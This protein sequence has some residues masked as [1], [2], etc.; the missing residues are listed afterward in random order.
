MK[1][2][3]TYLVFVIVQL[4]PCATAQWVQTSLN[5]SAALCLAV[6]GANLFAGTYERG[7][8]LSTDGG[9]SWT[10]VNA[11]LPKASDNTVPL[12]RGFA[13]IGTYLFAG[14]PRGVFL[15][16]NNGTNWGGGNVEG[17]MALAASG[18]YL[19]AGTINRGVF[20]STDSGTTWT[21]ANEGLRKFSA[22]WGYHATMCFALNGQN[23]F[24]GTS[25]MTGPYGYGVFLSTNIGTN[26]TAVNGGLPWYPQF[27]DSGTYSGIS[28][29][30]VSGS[31]IFAGTGEDGIF[32]STNN[33]ANWTAVNAG[34]TDTTVNARVV[35]ARQ[36]SPGPWAASFFQ[37]TRGPAGL[38]SMP[39]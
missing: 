24:I 11:G 14:T 29:F 20:L 16:T 15:S 3:I 31:N 2:R 35:W 18:S 8:F 6:S 25:G 22:L 37:P 1:T 19:F 9:T 7:I 17:V 39:A 5:S 4:C 12:V 10:E 36:S 38:R 34:L 28:C 26:W 21:A 23:L 13:A 33:G 32:V 27:G 30:A